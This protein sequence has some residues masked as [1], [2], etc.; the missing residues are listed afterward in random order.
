MII[1]SILGLS[2]AVVNLTKE[3]TVETASGTLYSNDQSHIV[4]STDSRAEH[5]HAFAFDFGDCIPADDATLIR[6]QV[7][8]GKIVLVDR[9]VVSDGQHITELMSA[10]GAVWDVESGFTCFPLPDKAGQFYCIY[11]SDEN[12]LCSKQST[13]RHLDAVSRQL[14]MPPPPHMVPAMTCCD[15]NDMSCMNP[16]PGMPVNDPPPPPVSSCC[17][18]NLPDCN[19]PCPN[20]PVNEPP[21]PPVN[22]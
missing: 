17:D 5:Y 8:Q 14:S 19:N 1:A 12:G 20:I 13:T 7:H 22:S 6:D 16:C 11:T 9:E 4:V 10:S 3:L 21:P 18:P 2:F 15:P